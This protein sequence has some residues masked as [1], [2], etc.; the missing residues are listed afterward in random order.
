MPP[1]L[2]LPNLEQE[3]M[4]TVRT[5]KRGAIMKWLSKR[6]SLRTWRWLATGMTV[7]LIGLIPWITLTRHPALRFYAEWGFYAV[8]FVIMSIGIFLNN[9]DQQRAGTRHT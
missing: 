1:G 2:P 7:M 6:I 3:Q 4:L 8:G 9:S 5:P